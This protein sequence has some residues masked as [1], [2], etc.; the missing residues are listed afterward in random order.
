MHNFLNKQI[1][2][3]KTWKK[4]KKRKHKQTKSHNKKD[5]GIIAVKGIMVVLVLWKLEESLK[6]LHKDFFGPQSHT[7]FPCSLYLPTLTIAE[8]RDFFLRRV[9]TR[10]KNSRI[11][12]TTEERGVI[13]WGNSLIW[14]V[15]F[16]MNKEK[17]KLHETRTG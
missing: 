2:S 3:F 5:L 6:T 12:S 11:P 10:A 8:D 7:F 9:W 16:K 14:N 4:K 13:I 1:Q 15:E 17:N